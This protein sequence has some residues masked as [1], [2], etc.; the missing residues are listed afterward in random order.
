MQA[1]GGELVFVSIL[2]VQAMSPLPGA[3]FGPFEITRRLGAGGMGEVWLARDTRLNRSVAIKFSKEAFSDRFQREATAIAS[4]NHPNVCTLHDIG[5]NYLVMEYVEGASPKGPLPFAEVLS[6]GASLCDALATAHGQ[7]VI[8]RD[9]KP[10]NILLSAQ[11]PKLL[12]F[13]L[14]RQSSPVSS[15]E[16]QS[17]SSPGA[18][19]GTLQYMAPEQLQGQEADARSDIF[20]LGVVL[21]ELLSG[22][23][24]F[25]AD[26]QAGLIAAILRESP[27][28]LF[29][30]DT[31]LLPTEK[32]FERLLNRCLEKDPKRRWQSAHDLAAELRWLSL[33]LAE[34]PHSTPA[35]RQ[36]SRLQ[37]IAFT[38][39]LAA[40]SFWLLRTSLPAPATASPLRQWSIPNPPNEDPR[41]RTQPFISPDG[42]FIALES[43]ATDTQLSQVWLYDTRTGDMREVPESG[44]YVIESWS[45]DSTRLVLKQDQN[46]RIWNVERR[47]SSE[48]PVRA[49]TLLLDQDFHFYGTPRGIFRGDSTNPVGTL[50]G[51]SRYT[52]GLLPLLLNGKTLLAISSG[53]ISRASDSVS[54]V[55]WDPTNVKSLPGASINS[56]FAAPDHLLYTD[57]NS[58]FARRFNPKTGEFQSQAVE[59]L[60]GVP[61]SLLRPNAPSTTQTLVLR[62]SAGPSPTGLYLVDRQGNILRALDRTRT[63]SNPELSPDGNWVATATVSRPGSDKRQIRVT[64]VRNGSEILLHLPDTDH[65]NPTWSPSGGHIYFSSL[66]KGKR[67]IFRTTFPQTG[68]PEPVFLD[69]TRAYVENITRDGKYLLFNT[70]ADQSRIIIYSFNLAN[71]ASGATPAIQEEGDIFQAQVSPDGQWIAYISGTNA[72][73]SADVFVQPYPSTGKRWRISRGGGYQPRWRADSR[74]LFYYTGREIQSVAFSFADGEILPTPPQSLFRTRLASWQRS[75]FAVLPDGQSFIVPADIEPPLG[76]VRVIENWRKLLPEP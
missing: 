74:E 45:T 51:E 56:T 7:G 75:S 69:A 15:D 3:T 1:M 26:S 41:F 19:I 10:A 49:N 57:S 20:S 30:H 70:F 14:A 25:A 42:T 32:R 39:L 24:A 9:I 5:P 36:R 52:S 48:F 13:G 64:N 18:I 72:E 8:H 17:I 44:G 31:P 76:P 11:G 53:A 12:D 66:H 43:I 62:T 6:L 67:S 46:F 50:I 2:E 65:V 37:V 4:L 68:D 34:L 55:S 54:L 22:R 58:L 47:Q 40:S 71:P 59:I 35:P 23:R 28:P 38:A 61:T 63:H 73:G 60:S 33:E 27:S 29:L 16:T 21:Y